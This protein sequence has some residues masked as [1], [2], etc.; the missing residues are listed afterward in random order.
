MKHLLMALIFTMGCSDLTLEAGPTEFELS[1]AESLGIPG[2][3]GM[4]T[5]EAVPEDSRC[6]V[7]V[8]CV[9]AGDATVRI[10]ITGGVSSDTTI[11]LHTTLEPDSIEMGGATLELVQ[12]HPNPT[13]MSPIADSQYRA[14]FRLVAD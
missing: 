5:F 3:P 12:L 9:W 1:I 8:V 14:V 10:S 11:D 4:V 13:A 6:P 2:S 7:D